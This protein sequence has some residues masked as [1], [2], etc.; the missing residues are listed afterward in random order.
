MGPVSCI[1]P[2][3]K[4][5]HLNH[6]PIDLIIEAEGHPREVRC[7]YEAAEGR[8][9]TV[10][11]EL[12][13]ELPS[14]RSDVSK[15]GIELNGSIAKNM[16][17]VARPHWRLRLTP[18]AAVAGAV[19]DEILMAMTSH[20]ELKR[21]YVNNG[22]DIALHLEASEVFSIASAA[23]PITVR[24]VDHVRGVATSGWRG[25]SFSLG[26]ADSVTVLARTAAE[27]DVAATLIANA[28]DLPNSTKI[29]RQPACQ[30]SPDSDLR[31]RLVTVEVLLLE[32]D[33][34]CAALVSGINLAGDFL[35]GGFV[36]AATLALGGQIRCVK[37]DKKPGCILQT[38][39]DTLC[40]T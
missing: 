32:P 2:D 19:A 5:L 28:V 14:L 35:R 31:E 26:I 20:A 40:L 13:R 12:V 1:L 29:R 24:G 7:A 33:E 8:F 25:R 18:M 10:L 16:E 17:S 9:S 22:G 39:E 38:Q 23:G 11:D 21:A 37:A 30:I 6:G 15:D 36:E 34:I 27:A 3:G 4:R